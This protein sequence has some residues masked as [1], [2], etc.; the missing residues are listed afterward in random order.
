[1][2]GIL[3]AVKKLR[4]NKPLRY[5]LGLLL[6]VLLCFN[7][8]NLLFWP[9]CFK[10]DVFRPPNTEV[11][12]S[13]CKSPGAWGVP[14]GE[15]VFIYEGLTDQAYLLDLRTGEKRKISV[16]P[17][18]LMDGVFLS[19]Q[20][21]W[22]EGSRTQPES[23]NYRPDYILDLKDGKRYE[24]LDLTWFPRSE[25]KFDPKYYEYFQ[26]ADKVFIHHGKNILIALSDLNINKNFILSQSILGANN[27]G[28][29]NGELLER[30]MNDL[31]VNYVI[32]DFSLYDTDVPSPTGK[33][34]I[35]NNGIYASFS[36]QL[37]YRHGMSWS[38]KSWYYD[39]SGIMFQE[40]GWHLISLP[41]VQ[42]LFYIPSPILKLRLP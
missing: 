15:T 40:A 38:F 13:A 31:G 35:R 10:E 3:G 12:V 19:S 1:M 16:D 8:P 5:V 7:L 20:W 29:K 22:L 34:A 25:G 37:I 30:L 9:L 14:D 4:K 2:E 24:L 6:L 36:D 33:Y 28:Y 42:D 32:V 26:S 11:L 21:V 18:L 23:Q 17:H 39:E 27:E 41:E